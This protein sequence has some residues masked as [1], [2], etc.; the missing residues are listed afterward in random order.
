MTTRNTQPIDPAYAL[1]VGAELAD[2][3]A[4]CAPSAKARELRAI[5]ATLRDGVAFAERRRAAARADYD[6][7]HGARSDGFPPSDTDP[8]TGAQYGEAI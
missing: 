8:S 4:A 7:R 5:A 6:A 3:A 2:A 1:A